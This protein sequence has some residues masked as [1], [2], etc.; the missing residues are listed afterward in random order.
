MN[1]SAEKDSFG[2]VRLRPLG[3]VGVILALSAVG[4]V[5]FGVAIWGIWT[6]IAGV[7]QSTIAALALSACGLMVLSVGAICARQHLPARGSPEGWLTIV[8]VGTLCWVVVVFGVGVAALQS[9]LAGDVPAT[10][11]RVMLV[12]VF[13]AVIVAWQRGFSLGTGVSPL[14]E[15]TIAVSIGGVALCAGLLSVI[16]IQFTMGAEMT[17]MASIPGR[18]PL[19][20]WLGV[21]AIVGPLFVGVGMAVLFCGALEQLLSRA[22]GRTTAI[23]GITALVPATTFGSMLP[24]GSILEIACAVIVCV[25]AMAL[26]RRAQLDSEPA[27]TVWALV[28]GA[29]VLLATV[30]LLLLD[31]GVRAGSL[32][33]LISAVA[34][35]VVAGS[36]AI[37]IDRTGSVWVGAVP[38]SVYLIVTALGVRVLGW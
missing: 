7:S 12:F 24:G 25:L 5:V 30:G 34:L 26:E 35:A 15:R 20:Y 10:L 14:A 2:W 31:V 3:L 27:Q 38:F 16:A 6:P 19:W 17:M 29:V 4:R 32:L 18:T 13:P 9:L 37:G 33:G 22:Y 11:L 21:E 28:S 36:G 1:L 23:A 8:G